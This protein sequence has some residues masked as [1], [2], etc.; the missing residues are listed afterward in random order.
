MTTQL[1]DE[2]LKKYLEELGKSDSIDREFIDKLAEILKSDRA[3]TAAK[4]EDA[5]YGQTPTL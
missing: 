4:I 5:I 1:V 3:V 2:I